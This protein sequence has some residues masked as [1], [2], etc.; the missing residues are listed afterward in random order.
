MDEE[1]DCAVFYLIRQWMT[2]ADVSDIIY[3]S[4]Y[5]PFPVHCHCCNRAYTN[6]LMSCSI[7]IIIMDYCM[8]L[9]LSEV[10]CLI[11][12]TIIMC[13]IFAQSDAAAAK[14]FILQGREAM[15]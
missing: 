9:W 4:V 2:V 7:I 8:G 3:L 13:T 15:S 6:N 5:Q 1:L 12:T 14:S 10:P 11:R